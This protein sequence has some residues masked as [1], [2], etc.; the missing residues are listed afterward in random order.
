KSPK[1]PAY[2]RGDRII[3][4]PQKAS[5][6]SAVIVGQQTDYSFTN[7]GE[8]PIKPLVLVAQNGG[9]G[10]CPDR[11]LSLSNF[12]ACQA[13]RQIA[14]STKDH[15][16]PVWNLSSIKQARKRARGVLRLRRI[17]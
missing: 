12:A 5:T 13:L 3:A 14:R 17:I 1:S 15:A 7:T 10:E 8:G 11:S 9:V 4:G 2:R 16:V 6:K